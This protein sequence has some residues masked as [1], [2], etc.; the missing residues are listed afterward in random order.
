MFDA[1]SP[2]ARAWML[3]VAIIG[4][5]GG[6]AAASAYAGGSSLGWAI[7]AGASAGLGQLVTALMKSPSD[8]EKKP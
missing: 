3:V 7:V 8:A 1:I 5:F 6:G 2:V 4:A